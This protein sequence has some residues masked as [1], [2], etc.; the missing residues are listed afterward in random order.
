MN[1]KQRQFIEAFFAGLA[2]SLYRHSLKTL[3]IT[4]VFIGF[5]ASFIPDT[6]I[7]TSA[8]ALLRATDPARIDYNAFR[9]QFNENDLIIIAINPPAVFDSGFLKQLRM[10][11][12]ALEKEVPYIKRITSLINARDT[13]GKDDELIV[14]ELLETW[15]ESRADIN[16]VK[17]RAFDNPF[18]ANSLLSEDGRMTT[19]I[20]ETEA[21]I[22]EFSDDDLLTGFEEETGEKGFTADKDTE[23]TPPRYFSEKE[24]R[25]VVAAIARVAKKYHSPVFPVSVA[26][27]P[28][29]MDVYNRAME[30]DIVIVI[31]LSLLTIAV[32][33]ALLFRRISGVL[34]PEMVIISGLL[35]TA[36]MLSAFNVT[37]KLT[38]IV[39]PGFLLAVS[40]GYAV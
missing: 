34:L 12:N 27:E 10:F 26:G 21:T 7:D 1:Q 3:L 38:T 20:L 2:R 18:Y 39:L 17:E 37:I 40:V 36:G 33:L 30:R 31:T 24:N 15:P 16:K 6:I 35:S 29:V 8:P 28:I 23:N 9:N 13:Y 4:F 25:E 5:L 11:H 32:F 14:G 22:S 19:I